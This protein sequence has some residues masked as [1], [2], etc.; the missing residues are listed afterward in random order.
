MA[1]VIKFECK[2]CGQEV[3][4]PA[5]QQAGMY[6]VLCPH[7]QKKMKV[8]YTPKPI[9]MAS[10]PKASTTS[11]STDTEKVR[12][13]P[14]RRFNSPDELLK[15]AC[16]SSQVP[17]NSIGRLSL[18]RLGHNKEYYQLRQGGNTIGRKDVTQHSDIE[19]DGDET[20]SRRSVLLTVSKENGGYIY[21]LKVLKSVNPV[22]VNG[23]SV[24]VNQIAHLKIGASIYLGQ[25]LLR[26]EK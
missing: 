11:T 25:T 17:S 20:M 10:A 19:I 13:A 7:C 16:I 2:Y 21:T 5:P 26:L 3:N 1:D 4:I 14:T 12:H 24:C 15:N 23:Q 9:T 18:V 8:Q 6:A 22:L